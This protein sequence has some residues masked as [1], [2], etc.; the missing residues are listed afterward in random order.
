MKFITP[1]LVLGLVSFAAVVWLVYS[2]LE[3]TSPGPLSPTHAR[4]EVLQGSSGCDECHGAGDITMA[5]GCA[6]CH[7]EIA[8]SIEAGTGLH[9]TLP[10]SNANNCAA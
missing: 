5:A 3:R 10:N 2:D 8:E 9:G 6:S 1:K 7:E 4:E